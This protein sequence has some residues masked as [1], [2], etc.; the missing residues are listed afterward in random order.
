MSGTNKPGRTIGP[1]TAAATGGTVAGAAAA[2]L[3]VW[4]LGQFGIDASEI[5]DE[6][7]VMLPII[8]AIIGGWMAPAQR[9]GDHVR[10]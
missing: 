10:E 5:R 4:G 8:G 3:I 7:G 6:L 1:V 2:G 9:G